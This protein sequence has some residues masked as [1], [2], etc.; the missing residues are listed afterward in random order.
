VCRE[1]ERSGGHSVMV[2]RGDLVLY[3]RV[4]ISLSEVVPGGGWQ[5][6]CDK[7]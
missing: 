6:V 3:I 5:F 2:A 4:A 7:V 1:G